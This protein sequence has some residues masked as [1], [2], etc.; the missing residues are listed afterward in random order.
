MLCLFLF[1]KIGGRSPVFPASNRPVED[2][3][4]HVTTEA[5]APKNM[6]PEVILLIQPIFHLLKKI[7]NATIIP[8][9]IPS[10]SLGTAI[11]IDKVGKIKT[12]N[13]RINAI[14]N[15]F[16][17]SFL[18]FSIFSACTAFISIPA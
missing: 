5:I 1:C 12:N 6:A 2:P 14:I 9:S 3:A 7:S 10:L 8:L 13:I 16:E 11:A 18:G 4:T 15:A 17:K